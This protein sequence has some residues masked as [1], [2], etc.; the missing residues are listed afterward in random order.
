MKHTPASL[1]KS[2]LWTWR[3]KSWFFCLGHHSERK[4]MQ[5]VYAQPCVALAASMGSCASDT[6]QQAWKGGDS[7]ASTCPH[8]SAAWLLRSPCSWSCSR[9]GHLHLQRP[10]GRTAL[11]PLP[12]GR[13]CNCSWKNLPLVC[14]AFS[15]TS[16]FCAAFLLPP[17][18]IFSY[19]LTPRALTFFLEHPLSHSFNSL[20]TISLRSSAGAYLRL[21]WLLF[22]PNELLLC[23]P[24]SSWYNLLQGSDSFSVGYALSHSVGSY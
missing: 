17:Q 13:T 4:W 11:S 8:C 5:R 22:S 23:C 24:N 9:T 10:R 12:A 18:L 20:L 7:Q 14:A 21:S 15:L 6:R 1:N 16:S 19:P 3:T 2:L